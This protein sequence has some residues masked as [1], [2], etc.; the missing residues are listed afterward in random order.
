MVRS[1][2]ANTKEVISMINRMDL[3]EHLEMSHIDHRW[4][5]RCNIKMGL[6]GDHISRITMC[7]QDRDSLSY[8]PSKGWKRVFPN[9]TLKL[10]TE[11]FQ[12]L[13]GQVSEKNWNELI[14]LT[15]MAKRNVAE[16]NSQN[17]DQTKRHNKSNKSRI[18]K[19][20]M[21]K[22]IIQSSTSTLLQREDHSFIRI[23][24]ENEK[25]NSISISN[26]EKSKI[27][28]NY[29]REIMRRI[30]TEVREE[31]VAEETTEKWTR[32]QNQLDLYTDN[33]DPLVDPGYWQSLGGSF[34]SLPL[35]FYS[36]SSNT[37]AT[38]WNNSAIFHLPLL[39]PGKGELYRQWAENYMNPQRWS[40]RKEEC[41]IKEANTN[42]ILDKKVEDDSLV[43]TCNGVIPS[44]AWIIN[45]SN[46]LEATRW[47]CPH[48]LCRYRPGGG[49]RI[50]QFP[51]KTMHAEEGDLVAMCLRSLSL[52]RTPSR[53]EEVKITNHLVEPVE[54]TSTSINTAIYNSKHWKESQALEALDLHFNSAGARVTSSKTTEFSGQHLPS[55]KINKQEIM[56]V[57]DSK[58]DAKYLQVIKDDDASEINIGRLYMLMRHN[59]LKRADEIEYLTKH[60]VLRGMIVP[61]S[62]RY[63]HHRRHVDGETY[64]KLEQ[65]QKGHTIALASKKDV[66]LQKLDY[67]K[68]RKALLQYSEESIGEGTQDQLAIK[69]LQLD[70][71][72]LL[73]LLPIDKTVGTF[74]DLIRE[75][76]GNSEKLLI[77]KLLSRTMHKD[78]IW[79]R[80][81]ASEPI[82]QPHNF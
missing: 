57:M 7:R 26:A 23:H 10:A 68:F 37:S 32:Y 39:T 66:D 25:D 19:Q 75:S 51:G 47:S 69:E 73:F 71:K 77:L 30:R 63:V 36:C 43:T 49:G 70:I 46:F 64:N 61:R 8:S 53:L 6:M 62:N 24:L 54:K 22:A 2:G 60:V 58:R 82:S 35:S 13:T 59:V 29:D 5:K 11:Y 50:F 80:S 56:E 9:L 38:P 72:L 76:Q 40:N 20:R 33:L 81:L 17:S 78:Q 41:S 74:K 15:D 31:T 1:A 79:A 67:R 42:A 12:V 65:V 28:D 18:I 44:M 45:G 21:N 27:L 14:N 34:E 3:H 48:C 16:N 52:M 55:C 4:K